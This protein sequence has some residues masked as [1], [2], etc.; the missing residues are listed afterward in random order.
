V[1][2]EE[3]GRLRSLTEK[4]FGVGI[5]LSGPHL[6]FPIEAVI[7]VCLE[8]RVPVLLTF[9]GDPTPFV[10]PAQ[11]AGVKLIDQVG[12]VAHARRAAHAGVDAIVAQGVEAGGHLAGDITTM[13]LVPR[14]VDAVAPVP[15][16]AAGGIADARGFAAA[17]ALGAQ[18]VMI[19]TR[20]IATTEAYAHTVYKQKVIDA[21][22]DYTVRTTLF[23]HGW[24]NAPHRT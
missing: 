22:E 23:G 19:G 12:S 4:P 2:R 15:V 14:V 6:P 1:L 9:W 10:G 3:I 20:L 16:I 13:A 11:A 8:E 21:A 5:L 17:L 7:E 24:P 18:G